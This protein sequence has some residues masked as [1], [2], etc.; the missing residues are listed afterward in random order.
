MNE[1]ISRT[2]LTFEALILCLPLT[3]LFI[4]KIIPATFYFLGDEV[5]DPA[6]ITVIVNVLIIIGVL[7]AWRL[8]LSF[9]I[10]G[11]QALMS[12]SIIWWLISSIIAV[13]SVLASLYANTA[14]S[15]GP[16]SFLSFGWGMF[17]LPPYLHLLLERRRKNALTKQINMDH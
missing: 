6:Y 4:I 1:K 5:F 17:F 7:S 12:T 15:Y 2:L 10:R 13:F 3:V 16:S 14:E 11:H 9:I 8:M